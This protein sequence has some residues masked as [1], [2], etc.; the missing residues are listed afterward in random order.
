MVVLVTATLVVIS[1]EW[2]S[3][4]LI[5]AQAADA[6]EQSDRPENVV[7]CWKDPAKLPPVKEEPCVWLLGNSHTYALPGMKQG[8]PLRTDA[9]G[10]LIDELA[11]RV[12]QQVDPLR[13]NYY[14]LAYPN[15]LPF[16]ML[17][18]VGHLTHHNHRPTIVF[19]GLTWRNIARDSQLRHEIYSAYRDRS[20]AEAFET[21]LADQFVQGAPE[22]I[23]E[24]R[25][26]RARVEH[27]EQQERLR[28]DSDRIDD[29]LTTWASNRLTLMGQSAELRATIFRML[30]DRVQRLWDDRTN[31]KYSYELVEH[32]YTF[33]V[34]CLRAMLRLLKQ[35]GSTVVC[36]FAPERSDLPPLLDPQRQTEFIDSFNREAEQLGI[37][38]L[39]ARRV[40]P[41]EYWGWVG[42]SPDRS[43]FTEPGHQL[44]AE[45]LVREAEKRSTWKE[46]SKP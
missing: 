3:S 44:L 28:S 1:A 4:R 19:V 12:D 42:D 17:T 5:T 6:T 10:I 30:T 11:T 13:A 25:T 37:T 46:L 22:V 33:N 20:F 34:E 24:V 21:M 7:I 40:V 43:H 14:L 26:Q 39:D 15:F 8:E 45:F 18:R 41:N 9:Q 35:N 27:E 2:G 23:K 29:A 38:V 36:Y 16:E 32:D 31:V